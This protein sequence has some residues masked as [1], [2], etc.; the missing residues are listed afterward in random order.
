MRA[1]VSPYFGS[2]LRQR[3]CQQRHERVG[4]TEARRAPS[5]APLCPRPAIR[6]DRCAFGHINQ[7]RGKRDDVRRCCAHT[8]R[9]YRTT[10]THGKNNH[11]T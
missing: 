4:T 2:M 3:T 11:G 8:S 6:N 10:V 9:G 5:A 7:C 1:L